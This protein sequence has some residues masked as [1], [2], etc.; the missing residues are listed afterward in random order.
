MRRLTLGLIA[1]LAA[2]QPAFAAPERTV[3]VVLF[4]GFSPAELDAGRPTPNFDRLKR[5]GAWSRHLVPAFPTVS[6]INHTTFETGCWPAHHGI[7]SN[8]FVDPKKGRF[9]APGMDAG[10]SAWRTG[11]ETIWEA[12][13]RQ[14]VR[15]AAFNFV[16]RWS[17]K[18]GYRETYYNPE[19]NWKKHESDDTIIERALKLLKDN[20]PNHARLIALYFS[21]PDS[22]AHEHGVAGAETQD[23]VRR[24]DAITG[25]LMAAIKALPPGREGTLVIG[26][27]HGM[28]DVGPIINLGRMMVENDIHADQATDGASSFIYVDKGE[29]VDRVAKAFGRYP[30]LLKVYRKGHYPAFAHLGDSPRAGDLLLVTHPPYWMAGTELYPSWAKWLGINWFWPLAFV[31]PTVQLKATHGFDPSIVEMHGIFFAWGAGVTP[32]EIKRLDQ[33]DVHPTVMKL[34]GLQPGRPVDGHA[35]AAVSAP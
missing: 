5:E 35:V 26:T 7:M 34:L 28:M 11:C 30:D 19:V 6:L 18:T 10:D 25:R 12:A 17:S 24:T 21:I 32:G 15:S 14:G 2:V 29:S 8:I 33:I 22:V 3:V 9:G 20:G 1:L 4:D 23:A 13:E 16:G 27:D 31:P